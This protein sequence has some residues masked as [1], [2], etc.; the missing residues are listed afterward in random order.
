MNAYNQFKFLCVLDSVDVL[1]AGGGLE[2]NTKHLA[3]SLDG[4]KHIDCG[5]DDV[6]GDAHLVDDKMC[7][8]HV[9]GALWLAGGSGH[10][11]ALTILAV[12]VVVVDIH[13]FMSQISNLLGF[14]NT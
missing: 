4:G 10:S 13:S 12:V 11:I 1:D 7:I 3:A 2:G 6:L 8:A 9:I 5:D 14:L